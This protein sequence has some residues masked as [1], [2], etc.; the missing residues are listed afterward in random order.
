[1]P[2]LMRATDTLVESRDRFY[3]L[4]LAAESGEYNAMSMPRFPR[5]QSTFDAIRASWRVP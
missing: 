5:L 1:M 4:T 3:V 2:S